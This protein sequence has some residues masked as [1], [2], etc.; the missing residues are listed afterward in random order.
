MHRFGKLAISFLLVSLASLAYHSMVLISDAY[1]FIFTYTDV[2]AFAKRALVPGW[3]Y[4]GKTIEYPVLVGNFIQV[5]GWLAGNRVLYVLYSSV[6]LI[7]IGLFA[8]YFLYRM[9]P[10]D[11]RDNL[12]VYFIFAPSI[13][14][15][16][17]YNWDILAVCSTVLAFYMVRKQKDVWAS[18]FLALGFLAKLYPA[19]FLLPILMKQDSWIKRG[20]IVFTFGLVAVL[21]NSFFALKNFKAW[22]FFFH[23]SS[24]RGADYGTM[25]KLLTPLFPPYLYDVKILNLL[26]LFLFVISAGFVLWRYRKANI[27]QLSFWVLL[28]FI[29]F[30]KVF[31]PQYLLWL[32]PF[33]VLLNW[34]NKRL[35][36]SLEITNFIYL[37]SVLSYLFKPHYQLGYVISGIFTALRLISLVWILSSS[38]KN[39][40]STEIVRV[41]RETQTNQ[42]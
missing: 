20:Q 24:V 19:L 15:F 7:A 3:M 12:K 27:I 14:L 40:E 38:I 9:V 5:M 37:I 30:N 13:F 29:L 21:A 16:L 1:I 33:F 41:D 39:Y 22:F 35:Y 28:L 42:S 4:L 11:Q 34:K 17:V 36:Y 26:S 25:W 18:L 23:F 6:S 10:D 32:L 31:S 2:S 8:L